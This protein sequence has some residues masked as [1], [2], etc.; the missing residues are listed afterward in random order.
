MEFINNDDLEILN[1]YNAEIRGF[2]NYFSIANNC[3]EMHT[4]KYIMEYSM[5]KTFALKYRTTVVKICKKYKR[6]GVFTVRYSLKHGKT[7]ERCFYSEGFKR[8]NPLEDA[9]FDKLPDNMLGTATTSLINR[10]KAE[11][12]EV[13]GATDNLVMHHV[14]KLGELK[15]KENWEKLMIARRRKAMAVCGSCHQ[16]IH[17]GTF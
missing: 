15:G 9:Y 10:L 14:R 1:R 16:K 17:H 6:N 11:K 3:S 5:Y 8:K 12:C 2:Y 13:C 4:F 7:A